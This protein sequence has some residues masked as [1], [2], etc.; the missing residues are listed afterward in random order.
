MKFFRLTLLGVLVTLLVGL[1]P[2]VGLAHDFRPGVVSLQATDEPSVYR[3]Q[4]AGRGRVPSLTVEGPCALEGGLPRAMLRCPGGLAGS[5]VLEGFDPRVP[6]VLFRGA[7]GDEGRAQV[8][9]EASPR[10]SL[11]VDMRTPPSQGFFML[12]LR[13]I[14]TGFDHLAFVCLL[15][16]ASQLGP[17]TTSR[18]SRE[19]GGR[20]LGLL[21]GFTLAHSL[22]LAAIVL[23]WVVL[24]TPM[25]EAWIALSLAIAA[26]EI[27]R[28]WRA[29]RAAQV[30]WAMVFVFGLVHGLGFAGALSELLGGGGARWRSLLAFNLGI[31]AGQILFVAV[32]AALWWLVR[33]RGEPREGVAWDTWPR[34]LP[35][36]AIGTVGIAW[37]IERTYAVLG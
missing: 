27:V 23:D 14:A 33:R 6:E 11:G 36:Y 18:S 4:W 37:T 20:L 30:G 22:S 10:V 34:L 26:A 19:R 24:R 17:A 8:V 31:E 13:H 29:G 32:L 5:L 12:G 15:V 28:A 2:R 25:I 9:T 35:L 3:L 21:T 1:L 7:S 16:I